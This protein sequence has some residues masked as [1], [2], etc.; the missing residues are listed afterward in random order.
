MSILRSSEV[1]AIQGFFCVLKSME[2]RSGQ[3]QVSVISWVSAVEGCSL[4][5][6]PL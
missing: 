6:V 5:G 3:S 4:S 1:S 2:I